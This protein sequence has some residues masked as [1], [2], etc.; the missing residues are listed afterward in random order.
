[1]FCFGARR[2]L[3]FRILL[4]HT[5]PCRMFPLVVVAH[6][7]HALA[8]SYW[9]KSLL[10]APIVDC[11]H[12]NSHG[13]PSGGILVLG[14]GVEPARPGGTGLSDQRVYRFHHPSRGIRAGA[15]E[16]GA[17]TRRLA[18]DFAGS[19]LR[20][21]ALRPWQDSNPHLPLTATGVE[22][23]TGTGAGCCLGPRNRT[24]PLPL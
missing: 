12:E 9:S 11:A 7:V 10:P 18:N 1:M 22:A 19:S 13:T 20:P 23:Q 16:W 21:S 6:T 14:A 17:R 24:W 8:T 3:R 2:L 15:S 5:I 4:F